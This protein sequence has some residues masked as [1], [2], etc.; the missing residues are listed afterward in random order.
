MPL[1]SIP[2]H[3]Q[4]MSLLLT[5]IPLLIFFAIVGGVLR[6][7]LNPNL[8]PPVPLFPGAVFPNLFDWIYSSFFVLVTILST[9]AVVAS[10]PA[11]H[12]SASVLLVNLGLQVA[13]YLPFVIRFVLLPAP[14]QSSLGV[15]RTLLYLLIALL[16]II[17]SSSLM[18]FL[19]LY[20]LLMELTGCPELQ[21]IVVMF[22]NGDWAQRGTIALAA[23]VVAPICEEIVYRG[24]IYNILK[25]YSRRWVAIIL[26][27]LLFSVIHG[28][29]AQAVPLTIF[30]IVQC[31]LYDKARSLRLPILLHAIYN[32]VSLILILLLPH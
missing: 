3:A 22:S 7:R 8:L 30:G 20:R 21:D 12:M 14:V 4:L 19:G 13:V 31:I 6:R 29:M 11:T 2:L 1:F 27:A 17:V 16:V 25:R 32:T 15:G 23:V 5:A 18:E 24:F 28:S 26:S 10:P 9:L